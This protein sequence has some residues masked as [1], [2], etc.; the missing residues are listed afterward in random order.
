LSGY[1]DLDAEQKKMLLMMWEK[2]RFPNA[3]L[4]KQI[5]SLG[6]DLDALALGS[7]QKDENTSTENLKAKTASITPQ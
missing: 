2:S 5:S 3:E 4:E 7:E 1:T 6:I